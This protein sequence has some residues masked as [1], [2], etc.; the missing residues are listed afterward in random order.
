MYSSSLN[1]R[2]LD[3]LE[4]EVEI[5]TLP[6][7]STLHKQDD[8]S[9]HIYIVVRG[10][11]EVG[12]LDRHCSVACATLTVHLFFS[13][14]QELIYS[15]QNVSNDLSFNIGEIYETGAC[16][17]ELS[18]ISEAPFPNTMTCIGTSVV[19]CVTRFIL[20]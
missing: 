19:A 11:L 2:D 4:S 9:T 15:K 7:G 17:G 5:F 16:L 14:E 6:A 12:P 13:R 3:T 20:Q 18:V 10:S 1:E 8:P